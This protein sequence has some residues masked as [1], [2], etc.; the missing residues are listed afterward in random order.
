MFARKTEFLKK[1]YIIRHGQTD[2]NRMGMVQG[3]GIDSSLNDLGKQQGAAFFNSYMDFKFEKI[4][5]S[6]LKRT[7]ET[8][9]QFID[10]GIPFQSDADLREISWGT[11]E[12][13]AFT[14]ET[15]SIYQ[16]TCKAWTEGNL[17]LRIEGG[18]TPLEV[19]L[20]QRKAMSRILEDEGERI[21]ICIHG[22]AM[23]IMLCWMLGYPLSFMDHF[24][25]AN[26]GL[27]QVNWTGSQ[28]TIEIFNEQNHL[29]DL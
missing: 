6:N 18:E 23:R 21:L 2:F 11:Q 12:G 13:I 8:V 17:D 22:R 9:Q 5:V 19:E 10:I 14:P 27:Y 16:E 28:F 29:I 1:L 15:S 20:R 25:H 4:Y 7:Q 24:P 26:T 3:S